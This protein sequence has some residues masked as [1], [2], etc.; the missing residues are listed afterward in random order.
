M[1]G[2]DKRTLLGLFVLVV[3]IIILTRALFMPSPD[4]DEPELEDVEEDNDEIPYSYNYTYNITNTYPHD[5]TA[6]T[7]G[8]VF[9]NGYLYEGTGKKGYSYI[10]KV[11]LETGEILQAQK[12]SN[13]YFGE[14]ITIFDNKIIQ[15]TWQA[16]KGFVYDLDT[17][18][19]LEEFT[20]PTEGWGLTHDGERLIMSDGSAKLYF[21]DPVSFER[22]GSV[23]VTEN[24]TPINLLN[25]LE[26]IDGEVYANVW[27]TDSIV[28]I[29]PETGNVTGRI[30]LTGLINPNDYD[31]EVNVLNGIAYDDENNRL[32]VTGKYWPKLFE[33][34]L[35]PLE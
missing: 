9:E 29:D 7:Q 5:H 6:F 12:L 3:G 23:D 34:E 28:R 19:Q 26:Y 14:G 2:F 17:F 4:I 32:F 11:E 27:Y 21:L 18:K 8:L 30:D 22:I 31:F 1:V 15:L 13:N 16:N 25:E 10:R 20:Y 35:V 33:I 24:G